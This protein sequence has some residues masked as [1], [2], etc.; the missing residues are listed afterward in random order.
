MCVGATQIAFNMFLL[1]GVDYPAAAI[2]FGERP[3]MSPAWGEY[4]SAGKAVKKWARTVCF[5]AFSRTEV[6]YADHM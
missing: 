5:F 6:S 1:V 3:W 2:C 4:E